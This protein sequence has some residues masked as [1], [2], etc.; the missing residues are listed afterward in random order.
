MQTIRRFG[1][2]D[3]KLRYTQDYDLWNKILAEQEFFHQPEVLIRYRVHPEQDSQKQKVAPE[4]DPLW[5]RMVSDRSETERA[6]LYGSSY[7]YFCKL[8][9]FLRVTPMIRAADFCKAQADKTLSSTLT[10]V[11]IPFW[12]EIPLLLRAVE[13]VRQQVD[14]NVELILIDDGSTDDVSAVESLAASNPEQIRLLRQTNCGAAAARNHGMLYARG[15]YIAFLDADDVFLPTKIARQMQL[16]QHHGALFSHTSYYVKFSEGQRGLGLWR[17][18]AFGGACFPSIIGSCPIAV[19][20][21]MLHRSIVDEGFV[22]PAECQIGEDLL[23]WIDLATKYL[24]LGIDEPLSIVEWS[25]T[26]AALSVEKQVI[27]L[28]GAIASLEQHPLYSNFKS[29]IN[30][31]QEA[32]H[33]SAMEYSQPEDPSARSM[34]LANT[35]IKAAWAPFQTFPTEAVGRAFVFQLENT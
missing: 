18:G 9:E 30:R 19:P 24:I 10:S 1:P 23:A 34:S 21:V 14:A 35:L 7:R 26:S 28:S 2:F 25:H 29:Q 6:Q 22:F 8:D 17:S 16:M 12:N 31:L 20:T 5:V 15:Q 11:I 4:S 3:E 33:K 27:G 32:L 13:S